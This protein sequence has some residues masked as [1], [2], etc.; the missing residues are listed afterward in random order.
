MRYVPKIFVFKCE[1]VAKKCSRF[2]QTHEVSFIYFQV[3][4]LTHAISVFTE[5]ILMMKTTLVGIIKVRTESCFYLNLRK[6]VLLFIERCA[7]IPVE[8]YNQRVQYY[9]LKFLID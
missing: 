1:T 9:I 8:A 2:Y 5:G 3:A 4:R 6:H 7:N